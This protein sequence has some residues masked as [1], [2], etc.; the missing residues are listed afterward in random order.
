MTSAIRQVQGTSCCDRAVSIREYL[1]QSQ[2]GEENPALVTG[3]KP[4]FIA[5]NRNT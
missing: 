4:K 3:F 5:S 1:N 2:T